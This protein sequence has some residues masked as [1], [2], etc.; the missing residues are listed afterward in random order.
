M[1]GKYAYSDHCI[2]VST[3]ECTRYLY[4]YLDFYKGIIDK[5]GFVGSGIRNIDRQY[6]K[7]FN[8]SLPTLR[9]QEK[10]A[11]LLASI[12][13]KIEKEQEKLDSLNEYKKGLLQQMFV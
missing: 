11:N 5:I 4:Y 12:D 9:E 1:S 3:K 6:L 2:A 13:S 7:K 10:I 8:V